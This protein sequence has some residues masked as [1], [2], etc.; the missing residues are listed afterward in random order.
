M[1]GLRGDTGD[2]RSILGKEE[3]MDVKVKLT[4]VEPEQLD[5]GIIVV[6]CSMTDEDVW[7]PLAETLADMDKE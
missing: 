5:N 2:R 4:G 1:P 3:D 6:V 7:E